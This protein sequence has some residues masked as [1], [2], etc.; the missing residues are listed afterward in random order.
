MY[1][2]LILTKLLFGGIGYRKINLK[3]YSGVEI[4]ILELG[5]SA[6]GKLCDGNIIAVVTGTFEF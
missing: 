4:F 6:C 5:D 1:N 3:S 2:G